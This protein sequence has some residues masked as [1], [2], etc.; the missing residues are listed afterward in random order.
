DLDLKEVKKKYENQFGVNLDKLEFIFTPLG[1]SASAL[2]KLFWTKKWGALYYQTDGSIFYSWAK[3]SI[4]HIQ[5]PL[6]ISKHR[7]W[8]KIKLRTFKVKNTN[9]YFTKKI[10]EKYWGVKID[11]V[12]QPAI[13]VAEFLPAGVKKTKTILNV[14]RFF[15][16]L[17]CKNQDALVEFFIHLK[18]K[19]PADLRGWRLVLIGNVESKSYADKV[20][21][22]AKKEPKIE[23]Y[24]GIGKE[25]LVDFYKTSSIY[26]HATGYF[27]DPLLHPEKMEH[28]G[29]TT[30]EAMAAGNVPVV[31]NKG[32]QPEVVGK[33]L[34]DCLWLTQRELEKNT[35]RV[36][37]DRNLQ[38]TYAKEAMRRATKFDL[39]HF[40]KT[41]WKMLEFK[42]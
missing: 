19:Y 33:K 32:G 40:E 14:G 6:Q 21:D 8:E 27:D 30:L 26:W 15:E 10:I 42:K 12:H 5:I 7:L 20:R 29:I 34:S 37:R 39:K 41:A 38:L 24:H 1:G 9:S 25:E 36:I 31:I 4:L 13:N 18:N 2:K 11:F 22:L 3:K 23:I 17:H 16:N 28:F 35:L